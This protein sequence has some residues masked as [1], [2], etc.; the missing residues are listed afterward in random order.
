MSTKT[1]LEELEVG[2][3]VIVDHQGRLRLW[4]VDRVTKTQIIIGMWRFRRSD[5]GVVGMSGWSRS[6]LLEPRPELIGRIRRDQLI[7]SILNSRALMERLP[8]EML[9]AFALQLQSVKP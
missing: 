9:E 5:G 1:W 7:A 4:K 6:Q 3:Q 8:L 2:S